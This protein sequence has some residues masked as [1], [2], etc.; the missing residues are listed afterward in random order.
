[1]AFSVFRRRTRRHRGAGSRAGEGGSTQRT[2]A[3]P[4][5]TVIT[6]ISFDHEKHLGS[7]L[8]AIAFEKAGIVKR[9]VPLVMGAGQVHR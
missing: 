3:G 6:N 7:S 4:I 8:E 9:N 2:S 5:G 1:M